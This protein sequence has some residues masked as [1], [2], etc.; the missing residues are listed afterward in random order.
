MVGRSFGSISGLALVLGGLSVACSAVLG[1]EDVQ[2]KASA[3]PAPDRGEDAA[4]TPPDDQVENETPPSCRGLASSCGAKSLSASSDCCDSPIVTGGTFLRSYDR[5]PD[6]GK[7]DDSYPAKVSDFRLDRYEVTVERF[8]KFLEAYDPTSFREGSGKNPNNPTDA[9]WSELWNNGI[10]G[11]STETP[12]A[13]PVAGLL[14]DRATLLADMKLCLENPV[15]DPPIT[16][17]PQPTWTD[18]ASANDSKPINCVTWFEAF[19]FCIWDGGRLPTEAEWNY[20]A[21]GGAE[22]RVYPW[23]SSSL[24]TIDPDYAVYGSLTPT[25]LRVGSKSPA[26]DTK[27]GQADM[28]GN[29]YEWNVD[30]W[31]DHYVSKSCSDCAHL[32]QDIGVFRRVLRGGAYYNQ[33]PMTSSP[34]I[35]ESY[36]RSAV[37]ASADPMSRNDGF[38]FRCARPI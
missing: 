34:P 14:P 24:G 32:T 22:H 5:A 28:A 8:R 15:V 9:G 26:G 38:G 6:G 21:S 13:A 10:P 35:L 29:V 12:P 7:Q 36:L 2:G 27:W 30:T 17:G 31:N 20:A 33:S 19:A 11:K 18:T 16:P 37:R 3:D 4:V 25:P 1:V 23:P